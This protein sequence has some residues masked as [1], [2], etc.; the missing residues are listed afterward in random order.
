MASEWIVISRGEAV[1]IIK[2]V[3]GVYEKHLKEWHDVMKGDYPER[4]LTEQTERLAGLHYTNVQVAMRGDIDRL[5]NGIGDDLISDMLCKCVI[6][7]ALYNF[8]VP[9]LPD[10]SGIT[11]T[12]SP[13]VIGDEN[14]VHGKFDG[15]SEEVVVRKLQINIQNIIEASNEFRVDPGII[16]V[17]IYAE[18]RLNFNWIDSITDIILYFFDTS[19]GIGQVRIST[20]KMLEDYGY[21]SKS[22]PYYNVYTPWVYISR[23]KIILGKLLN[24][25]SNIRYVAAYLK[26]FQDRWVEEYPTIS[27]DVGVLATL[28]NQGEKNPPHKNP[29]PNEFGYFAQKK[30][31]HVKQIIGL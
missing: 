19:V 31:F 23:E 21:I 29:K 12:D 13:F 1:R 11:G 22:L 2:E 28:Y 9:G 18:Q 27:I 15:V 14:A 10:I 3:F 6:L 20:A 26:Y 7:A 17:C 24:D 5:L 8:K 4:K 30:Y 25:K 16:A